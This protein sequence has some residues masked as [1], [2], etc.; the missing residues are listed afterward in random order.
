MRS[1]PP[2][3]DN[4]IGVQYSDLSIDNDKNSFAKLN[5]RDNYDQYL[6]EERA[7]LLT[8]L[9]PGNDIGE[10]LPYL[11]YERTKVFSKLTK[12]APQ[13]SDLDGFDIFYNHMLLV[14]P[15]NGDLIGAQRLRFN[16]I[17]DNYRYENSYLEHCNP[18]IH[19]KLVSLNR[20]YAEIGRTFIT[21]NYQNRLWLKELIRGFI[22]F[23]EA[24]GINYAY[25]MVSFDHLLYRP[26]VTS[27]FIYNLENSSFIGDL[28]IP[29][30]GK[31]PKIKLLN[32][33]FSNLKILEEE[34]SFLDPE[35]KIPT[36]LYLYRLY[37][38]VKYEGFTIAEDYNKILQLLFSGSLSYLRQDYCSM[39]KSYKINSKLYI[40]Y[41]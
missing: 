9:I 10:I 35:F 37:C 41:A 3:K 5:L 36:V 23:P 32:W 34:L 31:Y 12:S 7:D 38:N 39:L 14:N 16:H 24:L 19:D 4:F 15:F 30:Y 20:D 22:R 26:E 33:D 13:N 1:C 28:M 27:S 8:F 40:N 25:G 11:D 2:S 17:N 6:I 29:S 21:D 18:G